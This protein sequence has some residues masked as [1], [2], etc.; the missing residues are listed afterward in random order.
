MYP[1]MTYRSYVPLDHLRSAWLIA[2]SSSLSFKRQLLVTQVALVR[3]ANEQHTYLSALDIQIA[4][5]R[6]GRKAASGNSI[7]SVD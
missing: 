2:I 6:K 3:L 5:R 4:P 7:I 1:D